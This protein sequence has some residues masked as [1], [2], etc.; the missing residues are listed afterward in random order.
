MDL[1]EAVARLKQANL[2]AKTHEGRIVGGPRVLTGATIKGYEEGF[3]IWQEGDIVWHGGIANN[4]NMGTRTQGMLLDDVVY[5][6]I[7]HYFPKVL[8]T[9]K[10]PEKDRYRVTLTFGT[11]DVTVEV[12]SDR[13]GMQAMEAT[14]E[15]HQALLEATYDAPGMRSITRA[16][17]KSCLE[18]RPFEVIRE[19]D[20]ARVII[21]GNFLRNMVNEKTIKALLPDPPFKKVVIDI[22]EIKRHDSETEDILSM[23]VAD[24]ISSDG[25]VEVIGRDGDLF[26]KML[27]GLEKV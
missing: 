1:S 21:R 15:F 9:Q 23:L 25:K 12:L 20:E 6:I 27:K 8:S 19:G 26:A 24:V 10:L 3:A 2:L 17:I 5:F 13:D 22:S 11:F 16:I 7:D 18:P 14:S 4:G